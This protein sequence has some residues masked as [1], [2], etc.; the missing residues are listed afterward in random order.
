[1][2]EYVIGLDAGATKSRLALFDVEGRLVDFALWGPLNY[3]LLPGLYAQLEEELSRFVAG[4]LRKNNI[5]EHEVAYA[6]LGMAGVDTKQQH[7]VI[8]RIVAKTGLR[9]FT[10]LND[11]FIAIPA[12]SP[13]G[14]GIC[15]NNGTGCTLAGINGAGDM[16]Q[17]GGVGAV[18]ADMGGG[19][20]LSHRAL[21]AVYSELFRKGPATVMTSILF[22]RLAI[23]SK[24]DYLE[25]I[26]EK[27]QNGTFDPL[28][29]NPMV[30]EAVKQGDAVASEILRE[31]AANYSDGIC[32]MIEEL[33]F[34]AEEE[35]NVVLSGSVF[36]KGEHPLLL[37]TLKANVT[38]DH[39]RFN[40]TFRL[41][42]VPAVAGAVLWALNALGR[43]GHYDKVRAQLRQER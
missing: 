36:E 30:F 12:G 27:T 1:M 24:H 2:A 33:G 28:A 20:Y 15:A 42:S 40:I 41:L 13:S 17:I 10:L 16:L 29:C 32:C 26:H 6:V 19:A 22:E 8:S 7:G 21:A 25:K 14:I 3:E 23:T 11:A 38:A 35:L 39:P 4:A 43:G 18:S 37:D 34:S 9:R 31:V 5:A